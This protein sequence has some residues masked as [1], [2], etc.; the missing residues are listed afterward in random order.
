MSTR[1][2]TVDGDYHQEPRVASI[3]ASTTKPEFLVSVKE[4]GMVKMVDHVETTIA[5]D[6]VDVAPGQ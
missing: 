3:V 4:T 2:V 5:T 6:H 1:G